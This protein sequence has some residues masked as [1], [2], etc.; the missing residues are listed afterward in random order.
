VEGGADPDFFNSNG[1]FQGY[2]RDLYEGGI[3]VPMLARWPAK[4]TSG[5]KADHISAFWDVLPTLCE[6]AG[7]EVQGEIDGIS[8][9]PTF[10]GQSQPPHEFLYW[11][12]HEQRGKQAVRKGDWKAIKLDVLTDEAELLLFNLSE[13]LGETY[14]LADDRPDVL[15][16]LTQIM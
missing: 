16:E 14:N 6:V 3:R 11:E 9:L 15:E 13:D 10:I 1:P 8:F 7:A 2:K 4:I 12:F 5:S